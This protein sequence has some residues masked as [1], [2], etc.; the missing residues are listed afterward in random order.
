MI[1]INT[2]AYKKHAS[3]YHFTKK[4]FESNCIPTFF[5]I[6]YV[7]IIYKRFAISEISMSKL[8]RLSV[9][10]KL[11]LRLTLAVIV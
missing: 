8:C 6:I 5:I 1:S 3:L 10:V 2:T 4:H 11:K 9:N 7:P